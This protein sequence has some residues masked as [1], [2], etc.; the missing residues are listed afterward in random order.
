MQQPIDFT[1]I[2][3]TR[4]KFNG[5]DYQPDRDNPR[6]GNQVLKIIE[7]MKDECW[8]TLR[9]ISELIN[10]PEASISAQLRHLRKERFGGHTVNKDHLGKGLY[11]YQLILKKDE[12]F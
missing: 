12:M 10:E 9:Q 11:T 5:A 3:F 6:L 7:L 4:L 2:D 8:R 1:G